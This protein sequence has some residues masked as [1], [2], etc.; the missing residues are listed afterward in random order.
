[1]QVLLEMADAI[2]ARDRY[3]SGVGLFLS[4]DESKKRRF[5]VTVAP[6]QAQTLAGVHLKTY[7]RE[8]L[9]REIRLR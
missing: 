1:M 5:A 9:A 8:K 6:D 4:Q 2:V 3:I 7:V